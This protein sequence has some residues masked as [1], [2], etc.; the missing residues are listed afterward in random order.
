MSPPRRPRM[1]A[2]TNFR[3]ETLA[4]I[5]DARDNPW[6]PTGV[7]LY[8]HTY[9]LRT[10]HVSPVQGYSAR[11]ACEASGID[12]DELIERR[13]ARIRAEWARESEGGTA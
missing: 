8:W 5:Y 13:M 7:A 12:P 10:G 4:F 9:S 3:A 6:Y 2:G 1:R 11:Q